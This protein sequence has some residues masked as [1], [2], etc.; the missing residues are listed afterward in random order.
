MIVEHEAGLTDSQRQLLLR[1]ARQAIEAQLTGTPSGPPRV[2]DPALL[3][4][5]GAFVTLKIHGRLRGCIGTFAADRPL[6]ETVFD[7]AISAAF[8]DPRFAP[9]RA[10]EF[11]ETEI[12]ISALTPLKVVKAET[13]RVGTHGIYIVQG[14]YRGVLLP[15]VATEYGW[16]RETFLDQTCIKAGLGPGCWKES[17]TRIYTFSA[18][19]FSEKSQGT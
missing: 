15:Q 8:N 11:P 16:D 4:L 7:M 1:I 9:L 14:P 2:S 6:H 3:S 13:I 10:D 12:E 19:V 5:R 18:E 17:A